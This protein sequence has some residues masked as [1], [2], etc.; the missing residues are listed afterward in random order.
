VGAKNR[1]RVNLKIE[2][3]PGGSFKENREADKVADNLVEDLK[4]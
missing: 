3:P 2:E 4:F 1:A